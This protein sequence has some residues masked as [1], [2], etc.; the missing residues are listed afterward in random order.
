MLGGVFPFDGELII[1]VGD[2]GQTRHG[3]PGQAE[4]RLFGHRAGQSDRAFDDAELVLYV[5]DTLK[6]DADL[7]SA[8]PIPRSLN[9]QV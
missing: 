2:A 9:S 3:V 6:A 8:R 5:A 4:V 1:H 7:T